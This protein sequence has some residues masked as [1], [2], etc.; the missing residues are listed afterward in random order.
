MNADGLHRRVLDE[1]LAKHDALKPSVTER[2]ELN[3]VWHRMKTWPGAVDAIHKLREVYTTTVLTVMSYS[4]VVGCSKLLGHNPDEVMMVATHA[5]D[6]MGA[7]VAGL[8]MAFIHVE[9]EWTDVFPTPEPVH[10]LNNFD[11]S[12]SNWA[13]LVEKLT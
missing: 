12:A 8:T 3:Q 10:S 4:I 13:E 6:L 11:V 2:D 7:K 9:N 5:A 1:V